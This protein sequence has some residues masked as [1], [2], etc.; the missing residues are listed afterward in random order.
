MG[1]LLAPVAR[2][3][4]GRRAFTEEDLG[5]LRGC[6]KL[7]SSGMPLPEIKHYARLARQGEGNEAERFE[8]LRRHETK[9]KQQVTDLQKVL[10]K[11]QFKI[12]IYARAI[13]RGTADRLW[14]NGPEC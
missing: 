13:D 8:I 9:V 4:S 11:I 2:D 6:T 12:E 5:W 10:E 14:L 7:R 1:L 3:A